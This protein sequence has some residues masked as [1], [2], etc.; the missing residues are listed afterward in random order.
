[1]NSTLKA[2]AGW[3]S[4]RKF[5]KSQGESMEDKSFLCSMDPYYRSRAEEAPLTAVIVFICGVS[6]I[7]IAVTAILVR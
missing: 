2:L 7:L 4:W 6:A 3:R 1:M 5:I